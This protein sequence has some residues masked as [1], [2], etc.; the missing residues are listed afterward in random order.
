VL[1]LLV[2]AHRKFLI[3]LKG[4]FMHG[5]WQHFSPTLVVEVEGSL[6]IRLVALY[7]LV[8]V[9]RRAEK[10]KRTRA[11]SPRLV[12]RGSTW[13]GDGRRRTTRA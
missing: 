4:T 9:W 7:A 6:L 5:G 2:L 8:T 13:R 12:R 11:C 10:E 1:E 3:I